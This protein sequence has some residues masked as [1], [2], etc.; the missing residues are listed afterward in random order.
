MFESNII[1]KELN[2]I[3]KIICI[4]VF[5]SS[6]L[7]RESNTYNNMNKL[8]NNYIPKISIFVPIY[9]KAKYLKRSISSIQRQTL[10]DIEIILVNDF[11]TDDSFK[12]IK[13]FAQ[14]DERIKIINNTKN[15]G[16][17]FSRAM[18]II[19]S[20]GEYLMNLD[21]DDQL[22]GKNNLNYLY[23]T[24]KKLNVDFI[25]FFIFFLPNRIKSGQYFEFNII[26]KQPELFQSAFKDDFLKDFYI[27]NKLVKREILLKAFNV[28]KNEIYGEKWNYHED[29]IWSILIYKYS[30]SSVFVNKNVY[31]YYSKNTD[32][33]MYNRGNVLEL[34][35]LV[36]KNK[37]IKKILN[38]KEEEQY[39]INEHLVHLTIFEEHIDLIRQNKEIK[40][41]IINDL[42]GLM[43][44]YTLTNE[45][46]N[47][48]ITLINN[49][50]K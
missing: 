41:K 26:V 36:Y 3:I 38:N 16:L 44:N 25:T 10:K 2:I 24:A 39:V 49:I 22:L 37:M 1:L 32:S 31:C 35:N 8:N 40:D 9:N 4:I 7:N 33:E 28:F 30:N 42:K 19:N 12:I 43:T 50:E 27:T 45:F 14:K 29:N 17:L 18:G 20:K 13:E 34:K 6:F 47:R 23:N 21:P 46:R 11:S 48:I 5:I 15:S